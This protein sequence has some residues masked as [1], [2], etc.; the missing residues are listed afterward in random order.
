MAKVT[1]VKSTTGIWLPFETFNMD[2][3]TATGVYVIWR[4]GCLVMLSE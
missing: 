2:K 4:P 3:V 1:W